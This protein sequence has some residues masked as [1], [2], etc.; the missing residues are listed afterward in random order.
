MFDLGQ[1]LAF[2]VGFVCFFVHEGGRIRLD[3]DQ[4]QL[5]Q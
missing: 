4:L 5:I 3:L 1:G 2:Y